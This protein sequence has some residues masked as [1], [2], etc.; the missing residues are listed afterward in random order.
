M[1]KYLQPNDP[2]IIAVASDEDLPKVT[3]P[4]LP[5]GDAC[6]ITDFILDAVA[7]KVA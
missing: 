6:V 4:V 7:L 3:V 2:H 1:T 5:L